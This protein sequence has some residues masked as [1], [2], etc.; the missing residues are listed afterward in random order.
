MARDRALPPAQPPGE[1][2]IL[3]ASHT[4]LSYLFPPQQT[5]MADKSPERIAADSMTFDLR[6][7]QLISLNGPPA[8]EAVGRGRCP[9]SPEES[10]VSLATPTSTSP[11][12]KATPSDHGPL[13]CLEVA[14][15][16]PES[17]GRQELSA[18]QRPPRCLQ[19]RLGPASQTFSMAT[20]G[21]SLQLLPSPL[22]VPDNWGRLPL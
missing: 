7:C 11:P 15:P 10:R 21:S 12:R 2:S 22:E 1:G 16:T 14:P 3:V 4:E 6:K 5:P 20:V 13:A 18:A 19:G 17:P 9:H 8:D